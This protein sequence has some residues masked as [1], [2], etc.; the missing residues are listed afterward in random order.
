M[1][2][3]ARALAKISGSSSS[4]RRSSAPQADLAA[5][6]S[7]SKIRFTYGSKTSGLLLFIQ[8]AFLCLFPFGSAS[9]SQKCSKLLV[10]VRKQV[11]VLIK[12]RQLLLRND[13][14]EWL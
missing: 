10:P 6:L 2:W 4:L 1:C 13:G 3:T 11:Q 14:K 5:F 9:I 12:L 8:P 7:L